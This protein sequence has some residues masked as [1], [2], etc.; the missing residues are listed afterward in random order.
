MF[1]C[2]SVPG[3]RPTPHRRTSQTP[4][5]APARALAHAGP[6][7]GSPLTPH[8]ACKVLSRKPIAHSVDGEADVLLVLRREGA[9]GRLRLLAAQLRDALEAEDGV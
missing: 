2:R 9:L 4:V 6:G 3:R 5:H 8:L 7:P 1:G